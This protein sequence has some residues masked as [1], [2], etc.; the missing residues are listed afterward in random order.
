VIHA[1]TGNPSVSNDSNGGAPVSNRVTRA[2]VR[3]DN[4]PAAC[5]RW[6]LLRL[7]PRHT[8]SSGV[9]NHTRRQP[10]DPPRRSHDSHLLSR[11][12]HP[13]SPRCLLGSWCRGWTSSQQ[14]ADRCLSRRCSRRAFARISFA[15]VTDDI[16]GS[17]NA[18]T[19]TFSLENKTYEIDLSKKNRAALEKALKPYIDAG[20]KAPKRERRSPGLLA[21]TVGH[22]RN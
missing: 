7:T 22:L 11:R 17:T 4:T 19:I 5:S 2:R 9:D 20:R 16:N 14:R 12:W 3:V 13:C 1:T 18:G 6:T 15:Q 21:S 8:A 10:S